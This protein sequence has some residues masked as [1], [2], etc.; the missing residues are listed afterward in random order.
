MKHSKKREGMT[1]NETVEDP[2]GS[3]FFCSAL[4]FC[5][6]NG[7]G[8]QSCVLESLAFTK[9][10]HYKP[11]ITANYFMQPSVTFLF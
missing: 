5:L 6:T 8:L 7:K 3:M 4:A 10:T 2:R 9:F 11:T 1:D